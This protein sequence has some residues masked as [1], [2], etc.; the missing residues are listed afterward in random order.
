MTFG[1]TWGLCVRVC[2]CVDFASVQSQVAPFPLFPSSKSLHIHLLFFPPI[3]TKT[4]LDQT[5]V[6]EWYTSSDNL[7][8]GKLFSRSEAASFIQFRGSSWPEAA[9]RRNA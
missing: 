6:T 8:S 9:G 3:T 4:G 1:I 5:S 2:A 7:L